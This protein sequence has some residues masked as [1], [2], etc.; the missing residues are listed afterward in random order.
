MQWLASGHFIDTL[1]VGAQA[2]A[3]SAS[4]RAGG[5]EASA[6]GTSMSFILGYQWFWDSFSLQL[7]MGAN[8][9]TISSLKVSGQSE[10]IDLRASSTGLVFRLGFAI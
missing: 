5:S 7:G 2:L 6:S 10:P 4:A 1:F 8:T 3:V 9:S